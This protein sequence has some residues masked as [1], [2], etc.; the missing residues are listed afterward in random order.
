MFRVFRSLA[1]IGPDAEAGAV[2]V[3][4]FDGVHAGHRRLF[5]RVVKASMEN[6]WIPSVLT[7]D[8]HP[9]RVVAP[10]P[11]SPAAD[12]DRRTLADDARRRYRAGLCAAV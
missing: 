10:E 5:R 2:A 9:T 7:F 3:G 12:H 6:G 1:E 4:N 8:P 11:R